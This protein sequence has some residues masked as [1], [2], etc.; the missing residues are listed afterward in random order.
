MASPISSMFTDPVGA[1]Q[2]MMSKMTQETEEQ[3]RKR[4]QQQKMQAASGNRGAVSSLFNPAG[5]QF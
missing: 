3:R 4:L 1:A 2:D 5:N